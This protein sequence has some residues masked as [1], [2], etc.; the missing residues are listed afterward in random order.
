M[1]CDDQEDDK[2]QHRKARYNRHNDLDEHARIMLRGFT[3]TIRPCKVRN[4]RF[5]VQLTHGDKKRLIRLLRSE[6]IDHISRRPDVSIV[7]D[8]SNHIFMKLLEFLRADEYSLIAHDIRSHKSFLH[9]ALYGKLPRFT[10]EIHSDLIAR[11]CFKL[12]L[13]TVRKVYLA[14]FQPVFLRQLLYAFRVSLK[15]H[16]PVC[17]LVIYRQLIKHGKNIISVSVS[18]TVARDIES[19][20][21]RILLCLFH[22]LAVRKALTQLVCIYSVAEV[23]K[24]L[25]LILH[26]KGA[27]H[28]T[29]I[30][31]VHAQHGHGAHD[32]QRGQ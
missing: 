5:K 32:Y 31:F 15:V 3:V 14:F 23:S 28:G 7:T 11:L 1:T 26:L 13:Q 30:V 16:K 4:L 22:K 12:G 20:Y 29:V 27:F 9:K 25:T 24:N 6:D 18:L 21:L 2:K 10:Q 8:A 17:L 19:C